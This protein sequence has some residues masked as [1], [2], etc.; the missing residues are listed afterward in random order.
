MDFSGMWYSFSLLCCSL[1]VWCCIFN[2]VKTLIRSYNVRWK[3]ENIFSPLTVPAVEHNIDNI[4]IYT[5]FSPS[6]SRGELSTQ[7]NRQPLSHQKCGRF[8][9]STLLNIVLIKGLKASVLLWYFCSAFCATTLHFIH[10]I[11]T[12]CQLL[13]ILTHVLPLSHK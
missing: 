12:N 8:Y 11:S 3:V 1:V 9:W 6:S 7:R 5:G 2:F 10:S 13:N 4:A